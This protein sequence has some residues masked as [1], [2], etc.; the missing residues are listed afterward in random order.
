RIDRVQPIAELV[1]RRR[2]VEAGIL[3][4]VCQDRA[5]GEAALE[6]DHGNPV[7]EVLD[8]VERPTVQQDAVPVERVACAQLDLVGVAGVRVDREQLAD[9]ALDDDE[10]LAVWGR[11]DSVDVGSSPEDDPDEL[12]GLR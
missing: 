10:R 11:V 2:D 12:Y 9:V 8:D 6:L 3:R 4:D 1:D 5:G 7:L